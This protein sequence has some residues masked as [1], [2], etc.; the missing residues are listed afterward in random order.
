MPRNCTVCAHPERNAIDEALFR[1]KIPFRNVSKQYHVTVSALFRHKKHGL[2][3]EPQ[4]VERKLADTEQ[5]VRSGAELTASLPPKKQAYVEG[6]IAGKSKRQAAL[7]AGFSE[8]MSS[9]ATDK[10]E[11]KDVREAFTALI[12]ETVSADEIAEALRAGMKA[13]DTKF[14]SEKGVVQDQRDVVAWSER[15]QYAQLAAEYGR[16]YVPDEGDRN[17]GSGVIIV[18]PHGSEPKTAEAGTVIEGEASRGEGP[19]VVLPGGDQ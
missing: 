9:H 3:A 4:D 6:R 5:E 2:G 19:I 1:N 7:A 12:R 8:S 17:Q 10:I 14:F 13:M 18:L 11:T 15:R 16:Y